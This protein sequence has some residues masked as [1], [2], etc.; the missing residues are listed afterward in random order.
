MHTTI[1]TARRRG[2]LSRHERLRV[3]RAEAFSRRTSESVPVIAPV[4]FERAELELIERLVRHDRTAVSSAVLAIAGIG[5][6]GARRRAVL[7]RVS[8]AACWAQAEGAISPERRAQI[9]R[10]VSRALEGPTCGSRPSGDVD[11][12]T[13][14]PDPGRRRRAGAAKRRAA[15]RGARRP[16]ARRREA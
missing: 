14:Q 6:G 13:P 11:A 16:A 4:K 9:A 8:E 7:A 2:H 1:H 10:H 3:A 5:A 15:V 12:H